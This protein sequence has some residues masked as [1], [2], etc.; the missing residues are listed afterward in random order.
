MKIQDLLQKTAILIDLKA[1]DKKELLTQ[2]AEY[3]SS[4][5]NLKDAA[6]VVQKILE[7][8]LELSTGIGYGIAIPHA[9]LDG[10]ERVLM[11]A[12]RCAREIEFGAIDEKPV[13]LVFMMVSPTNTSEEHTRTL[14]TLSKIMADKE[15]REK[16]IAAG[17]PEDF[18]NAIIDGENRHAR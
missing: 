10:I 16:A 18:L 14:T 7:R 5:H 12:A 3:L 8:E 6:V 4:L 11:V 13:R 17:G 2:M 1:S 9:R 15:V